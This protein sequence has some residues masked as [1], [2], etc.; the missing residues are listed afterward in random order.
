VYDDGEPQTSQTDGDIDLVIQCAGEPAT[1]GDFVW[2][3]SNNN[4]IQDGGEAGFPDGVTVDLYYC[5]GTFVATNTTDASGYYSFQVAPGEYYVQF[6]LPAGGY[7]FSPQDQGLDDAVDSDADPATGKTVCITMEPG[8]I[9]LTWDA[10][11][12]QAEDSPWTW[13]IGPIVGR[14]ALLGITLLAIVMYVAVP[15][16]P[17]A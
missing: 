8:E 1:I 14:S 6:A 5:N 12:Y 10:G 11:L 9:D 4:G 13:P 15:R 3:D 2:V 7:I 17:A 16:R